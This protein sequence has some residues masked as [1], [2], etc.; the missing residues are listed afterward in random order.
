M[1]KFNLRNAKK[2]N[3]E[4]D[5]LRIRDIRYCIEILRMIYYTT[6]ADKN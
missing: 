4:R 2:D 6:D 3:R 5:S 1:S